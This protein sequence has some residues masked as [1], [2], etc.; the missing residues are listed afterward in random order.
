MHEHFKQ[1]DISEIR[2]WTIYLYIFNL[3]KGQLMKSC[4]KG[5]VYTFIRSLDYCFSGL[6]WK[7]YTLPKTHIDEKLMGWT[8]CMITQ[9]WNDWKSS[10]L[11]AVNAYHN[12]M[13]LNGIIVINSIFLFKQIADTYILKN[14]MTDTRDQEII[15]VFKR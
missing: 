5:G 8:Y 15:P 13:S 4:S 6:L 9:G 10:L 2:I 14:K 1:T 12:Y 7:Q 11:R 3:S